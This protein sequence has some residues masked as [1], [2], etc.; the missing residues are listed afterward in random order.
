MWEVTE[1][2][3]MKAWRETRW[4][5]AA[6]CTY[7]LIG[8]AINYQSHQSP[9]AN[10]RGMLDLLFFL[11]ASFVMPL[12]GSGV[13]SQAPVGFPEGLAGSTQFTLSLPVTRLRL[14]AVRAAIGLFETAAVTVGIAGLTWMLIP[15]VRA[16]IVPADFVRMVVVT[17]LFLTGPYCAQVFFTTLV[18][19]PLS[20][21]SP[22][23]RS[24]WCFGSCIASRRPWISSA[25]LFRR[26][27]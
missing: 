15:S 27:P 23:G 19:E 13:K 16:A 6:L 11:L 8:L 2:L 17:L 7:L 21:C 9:A 20:L 12:G 3:A 10:P 18:D 24:C 26:R 5:L 1:M 4:R 25:R 14:L 22:A